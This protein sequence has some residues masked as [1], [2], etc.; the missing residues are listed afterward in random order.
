MC[1]CYWPRAG[2]YFSDI[3]SASG[4]PTGGLRGVITPSE[5]SSFNNFREPKH[6]IQKQLNN[7]TEAK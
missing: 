7:T 1:E 5:N 6:G 2:Y 3:Y 4:I